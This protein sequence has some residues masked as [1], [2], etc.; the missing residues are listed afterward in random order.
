MQNGKF[1]YRRLF[2]EILVVLWCLDSEILGGG[3]IHPPPWYTSLKHPMVLGVKAAISDN[4]FIERNSAKIL[5][6]CLELIPNLSSYFDE[7]FSSVVKKLVN[8]YICVR[9]KFFSKD[10]NIEM[11]KNQTRQKMNKLVLFRHL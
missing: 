2:C 5:K 7:H 8:I 4:F 6:A 9:C 3:G 10:T 11:K 1:T